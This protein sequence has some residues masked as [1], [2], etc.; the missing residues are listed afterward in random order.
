MPVIM[1]KPTKKQ[2]LKIR[3]SEKLQEFRLELKLWRKFKLEEVKKDPSINPDK[4]RRHGK[5]DITNRWRQ[6]RDAVF[7][8]QHQQKAIKGIKD[9][10]DAYI[11]DAAIKGK[12]TKHLVKLAAARDTAIR[13]YVTKFYI[14]NNLTD[15]NKGLDLLDYR[16][17]EWGR[18][19]R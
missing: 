5:S 14:S 10:Y 7:K 16:R 1:K 18:Y 9:K 2:L 3:E 4:L 11:R 19:I 8:L 17:T 12:S 15:I 13:K 6:A